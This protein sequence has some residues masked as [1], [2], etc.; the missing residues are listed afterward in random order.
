MAVTKEELHFDL[1]FG[2]DGSTATW[3]V[4]IAG[5]D[6]LAFIQEMSPGITFVSPWG[7]TIAAVL[8][9]QDF[10][11]LRMESIH[12]EPFIED[13]PHDSGRYYTYVRATVRFKGDC[14]NLGAGSGEDQPTVPSGTYLSYNREAS[15]MLQTMPGHGFQ[16]ATAGTQVETDVDV[17]KVITTAAHTFR[18]T[19]V[20]DPPW[21]AINEARGRVNDRTFL[22]RPAGTLLFSGDTVDREFN[23]D[24]TDTYQVGYTFHERS[25]SVG[26]AYTTVYGWNHF[27]NAEQNRWE[28]VV[29]QDDPTRAVYEEYDLSEL[30][31]EQ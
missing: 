21:D 9:H 17:G 31:Q 3:V 29:W 15:A 6:I 16:W 22:G 2:V 25:F 26:T 1:D 10:T 19:N 4:K 11:W 13:P 14:L 12:F 20:T 18:W 23:E 24:G 7:Y 28:K 30:F 8:T 27:W 5:S